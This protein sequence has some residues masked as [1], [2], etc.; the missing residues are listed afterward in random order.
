MGFLKR[1]KDVNLEAL[2]I[3][4]KFDVS[5]MTM[6]CGYVV[7]VTNPLITK[8]N[9][10]R[11]RELFSRLEENMYAFDDQLSIRREFILNALEARI[12]DKIS[13]RDVLLNYCRNAASDLDKVEEL[14]DAVNTKYGKMPDSEVKYVTGVISQKNRYGFVYGSKPLFEGFFEKVDMGEFRSDEVMMEEFTKLMNSTVSTLRKISHVDST[15]AFNLSDRFVNVVTKTVEEYRT[16]SFKLQTGVQYLNQIL[17]GGFEKKRL[18]LLLG[19]T[20]WKSAP[21][22]GDDVC[23]TL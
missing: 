12:V 7:D 15:N 1:N 9:L 6:F 18:Y 23:Q 4:I 14:I 16:P 3:P 19:L 8:T 22:I 21:H 10:D 2:P 17:G 5:R 11:A 20:G 13:N